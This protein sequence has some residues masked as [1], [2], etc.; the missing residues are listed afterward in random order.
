M[1]LMLKPG[2]AWNDAYARCRAVAAEAFGPEHLRNLA[3]GEWSDAGRTVPH[4]SPVDG[5]AM[6][7]PSVVDAH[8]AVQA[9]EGACL[10]H[11]AWSRT[12]LD[13]R[14]ERVS[15]ALEL[16]G[17]QRELLALLLVHEIGKPWRLALADVD[18]C[19]DGVRWYVD[20][21]ED[22]LAAFGHPRGP[23]PGPV[24]NIASWNY[25]MSVQIHAELVQLL[26]WECRGGQ[27]ALAGWLSLPHLGPRAHAQGRLAGD[28]PLG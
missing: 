22:Q 17:A 9:I 5:M 7:G 26:W 21:I 18:R 19:L 1:T 25:P 14:R 4:V 23:L 13:R 16:M 15:E 6:V 10:A 24:S 12:P 3:G 11:Q 2:T 28:A 20:G 8:V 27:D